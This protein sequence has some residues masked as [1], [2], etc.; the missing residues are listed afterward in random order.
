MQ[1]AGSSQAQGGFQCS[2]ALL[3]N[4]TLR[5]PWQIGYGNGPLR[6]F[7][8]M[9]NKEAGLNKGMWDSEERKGGNRFCD[10]FSPQMYPTKDSLCSKM[11]GCCHTC[12]IHVCHRRCVRTASGVGWAALPSPC[13]CASRCYKRQILRCRLTGVLVTQAPLFHFPRVAKTDNNGNNEAGL[14]MNC[15]KALDFVAGVYAAR[16]DP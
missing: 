13:R 7:Y 16:L 9:F 15:F 8:L 11:W 1:R 6:L 5:M 4:F 2:P 12:T 14:K 10:M 3:T